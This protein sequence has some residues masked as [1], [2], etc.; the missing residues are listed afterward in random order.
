[1]IQPDENAGIIYI[2]L[3]GDSFK[4]GGSSFA[5]SLNTLGNETPT[6]KDP[7][8]FINAFQAI[9][10]LVNEGSILAGHDVSAGGLAVTLLEMCFPSE[11]AGMKVILDEFEEDRYN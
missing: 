2:D 8:Y 9:Q 3:S 4:L 5:Q 1:M 10:H 11:K 7:R 6:V